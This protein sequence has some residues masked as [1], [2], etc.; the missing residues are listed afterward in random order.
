VEVYG[1]HR[2]LAVPNDLQCLGLHSQAASALLG[3]VR[4]GPLK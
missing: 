2:V 4:L 1:E 3:L